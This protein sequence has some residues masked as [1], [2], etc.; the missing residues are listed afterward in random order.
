[1]TNRPF[2]AQLAQRLVSEYG[3]DRNSPWIW[4]LLDVDL[5]TKEGRDFLLLVSGHLV[6]THGVSIY[7]PLVL[8]LNKLARGEG[9]GKSRAG[10]SRR[11]V[12]RFGQPVK[13][14]GRSGGN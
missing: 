11:K 9:A 6:K 8:Q 13:T 5:A 10:A 4:G 7:S 1:M 14:I 2:F 3:E 12:G